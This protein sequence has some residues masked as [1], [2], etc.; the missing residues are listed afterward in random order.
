M[1][2]RQARSVSAC[3][4]VVRPPRVLRQ[5]QDEVADSLVLLPPFDPPPVV[6][7]LRAPRVGRQVRRDLRKLLVR[8][9]ELVHRLLPQDP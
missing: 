1:S 9:S 8:P 3:I 5:A 7:A 2:G 6:H 4:L